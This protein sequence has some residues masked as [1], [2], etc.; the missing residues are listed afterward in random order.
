MTGSKELPTCRCRCVPA[1]CPLLH[2][3][4]VPLGTTP[5]SEDEPRKHTTLPRDAGRVS[6]NVTEKLWV[7]N[8]Q[9]YKDCKL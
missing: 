3:R 6:R 1:Q 9:T 4:T 8:V 2:T 5:D 7:P